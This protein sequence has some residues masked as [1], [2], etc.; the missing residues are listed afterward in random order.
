ML[1][2]SGSARDWM[3]RILI[4][5]LFFA[6]TAPT[7][8]WVEF[9]GGSENIVVATAL[10]MR[11]SGQWVIPTLAGERRI[12]KPP[13]AAWIAA[14]SID[15][16]TFGQTLINEPVTR[17]NAYRKLA[18]EMR[19]PALLCG[20]ITLAF[21]FDLGRILGGRQL[22]VIAALA[23][24]ASY[25]FMRYSRIAS[26]DVQLALW[27]GAANVFLAMAVLEKKKWI[28][29]VGAGIAIA[30]AFISKGPVALVQTLV[31][32]V[33]IAVML[34]KKNQAAGRERIAWAPIVAG[35]AIFL[36]LALPWFL[37]VA[38]RMDAWK[39][40]YVEV[41]RQDPVVPKSSPINYLTIF[42]LVLPWAAFFVAGLVLAL[43]QIRQ[44]PVP[45]IV[46]ALF[47][48][49][50]PIGVMTF[51]PDRKERYLVP[52][53]SAASILV[54]HGILAVRDPIVEKQ[55]KLV[56]VA[57]WI[58]VAVLAVG[59]PV[60]AA[61]P[62]ISGMKTI[63]GRAWLGW[64]MA[65]VLAVIGAMLIAIGA[66]KGR[67]RLAE[68]V[69]P[70]VAA[71]LVIQ[72]ALMWGYSRSDAGRSDLKNFAFEI[73]EKFPDVPS[74]S[75]RP[76]RRPPEEV[77]IYMN[78]TVQALEDLS[79]LPAPTGPQLLFVF[80]DKKTPIPSLPSYW[81]PVN[82]ISKGEGT[83]HLYHHP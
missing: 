54:A 42:V 83:W 21:T 12:A 23:H 19:W 27:V 78:R 73:R 75:Y 52:M 81:V 57:H 71:M 66:L 76:G 25:G 63:E 60:A 39:T 43:T 24:G 20:C 3:A 45:R 28:G 9:T 51:F 41:M 37:Y 10:E 79:K 14:V 22:G 4:P 33:L 74:F 26:T 50:V 5:L 69:V 2:P 47:L 49:I 29:Y 36:L 48:V 38:R 7:L 11:R 67:R 55:T 40:W 77:G 68:I 58:I 82:E 13:L 6:A 30:L 16:K 64:P 61:M 44:R 70:T 1:E 46:C 8:S 18:W 53:L 65:I 62:N 80:E 56:L 59:V 17:E 31:P 34:G 32:F 35:L 15:S 72:P